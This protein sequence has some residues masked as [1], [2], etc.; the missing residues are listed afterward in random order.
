MISKRIVAKAEGTKRAIAVEDL[1]HIRSRITA[2]R[3]QRATLHS[4]SF[5]QLQAFLAYKAR[6]SGIP[7]HRVDPRNTSRL[8]PA[9]GH[10]DKA[11]RRTQ[12]V[13][14]CTSCGL[15]GP[16]DVIAA[17]NIARR[18]AVNQPNCPASARATGSTQTSQGK[19]PPLQR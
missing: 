4:W 11:N 7:V 2:R 6:L 12:A 19:A 14:Y 13:F 15:A 18:A 9:C 10:I 17:G 8:C 3:P 16:A 5:A 1:T